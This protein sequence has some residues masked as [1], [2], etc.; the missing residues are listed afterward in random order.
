MEGPPLGPGGEDITWPDQVAPRG[1]KASS[2][3]KIKPQTS[4]RND[5]DGESSQKSE[6]S[7]EPRHTLR[8]NEKKPG[9]TEPPPAKQLRIPKGGAARKCKA[10]RGR[11]AEPKEGIGRREPP[12]TLQ[13]V[14]LVI[15]EI[16]KNNLA[17]RT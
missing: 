7:K 12:P 11:E 3:L 13:E 2:T 9:Y 17:K 6:S 10:T 14:N 1:R 8:H 5:G 16:S 4:N 15:N